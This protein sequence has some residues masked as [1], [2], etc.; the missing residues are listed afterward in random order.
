MRAKKVARG[1]WRDPSALDLVKRNTLDQLQS[2]TE[3]FDARWGFEK[4]RQIDE[5]LYE[6]LADQRDMLTEACGEMGQLAECTLHRDAMQRGWAR[7]NAVMEAAQVDSV[8]A[9]FP[10]AQV[11]LVRPKEDNPFSLTAEPPLP[12]DPTLTDPPDGTEEEEDA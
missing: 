8:V 7:A 6:A 5:D 3:I 10:G 9:L 11:A 12:L 2:T 1:A 4:L